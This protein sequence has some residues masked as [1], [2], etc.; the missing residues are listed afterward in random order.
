[1]MS[2]SSTNID[3]VRQFRKHLRLN[4]SL[5][6]SLLSA[7]LRSSTFFLLPHP[8]ADLIESEIDAMCREMSGRFQVRVRK[9]TVSDA[10]FVGSAVQPPDGL[11]ISALIFAGA[12]GEVAKEA[13]E[14]YYRNRSP[15][16]A[17]LAKIRLRDHGVL[18]PRICEVTCYSFSHGIGHYYRFRIAKHNAPLAPTPLLDYLLTLPSHCPNQYFLSGP[19]VSNCSGETYIQ[20]AHTKSHPIIT[21]ARDALAARRY[22]SAHEDVEKFLLENDPVAI[23]SEVPIWLEPSELPLLGASTVSGHGLTGHIDVLRCQGDTIEIWDFK[24]KAASEAS[25][26]L[27]VFLYALLLSTRT[28]IPISSFRCG[29]FDD[30]DAFE[31]MATQVAA[32]PRLSLSGLMTATY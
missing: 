15:Q 27:Q 18:V 32:P 7:D 17:I 29:Y 19:R 24:P 26:A 10:P 4:L 22:K 1:M 16:P 6:R 11:V 5:I 30:E 21:L 28:G 3:P 25:A 8:P 31:F 13:I 9:F 2:R 14:A 23:A 20:L 12:T